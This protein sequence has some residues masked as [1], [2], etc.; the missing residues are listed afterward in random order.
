MIYA[1][2]DESSEKLEQLMKENGIEY[3]KYDLA[4]EASIAAE[5]EFEISSIREDG[6]C[7]EK[8]KR[9]LEVE[10]N[11]DHIVNTMLED[12]EYLFAEIS[13]TVSSYLSDVLGGLSPEVEDVICNGA[14][15][16]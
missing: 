5:I 8:E 1:V 2:K 15:E 9:L 14:S 4:S 12:N 16:L 7:A 3:K 10:K 11:I 13:D 6:V